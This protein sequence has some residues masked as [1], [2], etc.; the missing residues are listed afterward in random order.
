MQYIFKRDAHQAREFHKD[1]H[2][3]EKG[4]KK[5]SLYLHIVLCSTMLIPFCPF[6]ELY[7]LLNTLNYVYFLYYVFIQYIYICTLWK[8]SHVHIKYIIHNK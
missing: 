3:K 7:I 6:L 8:D 5:Y 1:M 2:A 4:W